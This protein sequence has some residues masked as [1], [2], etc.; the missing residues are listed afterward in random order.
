MRRPGRL[1]SKQPRQIVARAERLLGRPDSNL[2]IKVRRRTQKCPLPA[3][4]AE[5]VINS[6]TLQY[7]DV[8]DHFLAFVLKRISFRKHFSGRMSALGVLPIYF[9]AI[10][11]KSTLS[12]IYL[13][14]N[15]K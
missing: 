5:F 9:P 6:V 8:T 3:R 7:A 4:I 13:I 10:E 14:N 15:D 12:T 11:A 2:G 1:E